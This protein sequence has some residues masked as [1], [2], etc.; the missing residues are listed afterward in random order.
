MPRTAR[1]PNEH[2]LAQ[3]L[4]HGT[5]QILLQSLVQVLAHFLAQMPALLR[6]QPGQHDAALHWLA[7]SVAG[8][9]RSATHHHH[10]AN[11]LMPCQHTAEAAAPWGQ[12]PAADPSSAT[13]WLGLDAARLHRRDAKGAID[14][15]Q[16]SL[17]LR[18]GW[19]QLLFDRD[20]A[21]GR[22]GAT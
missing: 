6:L 19:P 17:A 20:H 14:A 16:R 18:P 3:V 10:D 12:A 7:R 21:A 11:A 2:D 1:R 13:G 15:A 5:V 8:L 9:P 22:S 4:V